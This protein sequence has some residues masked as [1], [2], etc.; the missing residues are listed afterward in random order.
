MRKRKEGNGASAPRM[1]A[2]CPT[3]RQGP[4]RK[5]GRGLVPMRAPG[6]RAFGT[7]HA[8][9]REAGTT[10]SPKERRKGKGR[11][12]RTRGEVRR[13]LQEDS[14]GADVSD[15][16]LVGRSEQ[17]REGGGNDAG[18]IA[19]EV[20]LIQGVPREPDGRRSVLLLDPA[21]GAARS[22]DSSRKIRRARTSPTKGS[23]GAASRNGRAEASKGTMPSDRPMESGPGGQ[24]EPERFS[25]D[26]DAATHSSNEPRLEIVDGQATC[27]EAAAG[28]SRAFGGLASPVEGQTDDG[29]RKPP[30][31]F[32][33]P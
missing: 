5:Q 27:T 29:R 18:G 15:E 12:R 13:L 23:S 21:V 33:P 19:V 31:P 17:E 3:R 26:R 25:H 6:G 32:S 7:R 28:T 9:F 8:P 30:F 1:G 24:R 2:E 4:H 14:T 11:R 22:V 20:P 16:R 10:A